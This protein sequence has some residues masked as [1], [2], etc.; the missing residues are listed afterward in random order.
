MGPVGFAETNSILYEYLVL[1]EPK[2]LPSLKILLII[3]IKALSERFIL[4]NPGPAISTF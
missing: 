3:E 1:Y 4:I 2:D